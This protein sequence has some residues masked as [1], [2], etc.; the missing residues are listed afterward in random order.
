[1]TELKIARAYIRLSSIPGDDPKA[2][3][4]L[5]SIGSC[6]I[7]MFRGP[8]VHPHGVPLCWLELLDHTKMSVDGFVCH[9]MKD[10]V[11]L[12]DDL[13]LQAAGQNKPGGPDDR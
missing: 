3:V 9:R 1:M 10:A 4:L 12:F 11:P 5:A 6:E 8:A 2:S 7:R 13:I